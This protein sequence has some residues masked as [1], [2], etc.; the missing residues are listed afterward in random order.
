MVMTND[1]VR[2]MAV[3][4]LKAETDRDRQR[5]I[6]ASNLAN[7]CDF[8]LA[9]NL[10][11]DMRETPML[12]RAWGGRVIGTALHGLTEERIKEQALANAASRL[13][14]AQVEQHVTLG[15]IEGY[16]EIG[17]TPDLFLPSEEHLF[18]WKG[19]TRKKSAIM[20]D[21]LWLQA[22]N[23]TPLF[24][25]QHKEVKI[26]EA[27]YAKELVKAEYR[28]TGYYAQTQLYAR[29]KAKQG[30]SVR[31]M[32]L[33]F[34]NRDGTMWFDNPGQDG[35]GDDTRTR[36]VWSLD[37]DYDAAFADAVWGRG[38]AVWEGLQGGLEVHDFDRNENCFP[39]SLDARDEARVAA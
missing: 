22:G 39:C 19:S 27:V 18:D 17:S 5:T 4:I 30:Y 31:R 2:R 24:G 1:E 32:S 38:C 15:E 23:K 9:S 25:R 11:G 3:D 26:S 16:G 20:R 28:I 14:D 10:L 12:D 29:G 8:C 33:I 37:F 21:F 35:W 6:G 34:V 36:D 7:G 13:A